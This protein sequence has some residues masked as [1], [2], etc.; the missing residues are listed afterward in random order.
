MYPSAAM[1]KKWF[2]VPVLET[3]EFWGIPT[4]NII[5]LLDVLISAAAH[6]AFVALFSER[7]EGCYNTYKMCPPAKTLVLVVGRVLGWGHKLRPYEGLQWEGTDSKAGLGP[8][9]NSLVNLL[10]LK[11]WSI[12]KNT[13]LK[14]LNVL[15]CWSTMSTKPI[16]KV[17]IEML[18]VSQSCAVEMPH[19]PHNL[20]HCPHRK[21]VVV[22][23][24]LL[25]PSCCVLPLTHR[26][27]CGFYGA[28]TYPY[29]VQIYRVFLH[30]MS[31]GEKSLEIK[32]RH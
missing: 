16:L 14:V 28:Q 23:K 6:K 29:C 20:L 13:L 19:I 5:L 1:L 27:N 21:S 7:L 11:Q 30:S 2:L 17:C 18:L 31:T 8:T 4:T 25:Y 9:Q 3:A 12:F 22:F 15:P 32:H 24:F 10:L 26:E